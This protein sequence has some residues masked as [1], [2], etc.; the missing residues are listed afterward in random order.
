M[1]V[2]EL[3]ADIPHGLPKARE[4]FKDLQAGKTIRNAELKTKK[5]NGPLIC[6]SL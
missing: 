4:V 1:K 3:Y 2:F 6:V 5:Y